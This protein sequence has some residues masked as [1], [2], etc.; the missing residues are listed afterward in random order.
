MSVDA[1]QKTEMKQ[2]RSPWRWI[3]AV[4]AVL[5]VLVAVVASFGLLGSDDKADDPKAGPASP[6]ATVT[7]TAEPPSPSAPAEGDGATELTVVGD[8]ARCI[9]PTAKWLAQ[10]AAL[11]FEGTVVSTTTTSAGSEAELRVKTW[12]YAD[13]FGGTD[14][15]RVS[16]PKPS[17]IPMPEFKKDKTYLVAAKGD[18]KVIGCGYSDVKDAKL[19]KMYTNA[20]K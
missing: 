18:A 13:G 10:N 7:E 9:P 8:A 20:F 15:V 5:V 14:T 19:Q 16:L 3:A 1:G 2:P 17:T 6:T 11:A 12:M 4:V